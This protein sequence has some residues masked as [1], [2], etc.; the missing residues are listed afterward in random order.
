MKLYGMLLAGVLIGASGMAPTLKAVEETNTLEIIQRLQKRIDELEQK[1]KT[2]EQAQTPAAP[3]NETK[4]NTRLEELGQKVKALERERELDREAADAKAKEVPK[5]TLGERGFSLASADGAFAVQLGGVLQVDSRSFFNDGGTVGNDG[6]LLRRARPT[7]QGTV[8]RDFD[9]LFVPDF[10]TSANGGNGGTAPTPQIFDAY[11]NY[12]YS[13]AVQFQAGKFKAPIG[14]EQLQADRDILFNERALP[15]DLVPVRDI[16]FELH[17][18]LF[19]GTASYAAGVFNGVG[20]ARN[21][22]LSDFDDDKAFEGRIF[23][24]PFK[25]LS[26]SELQGFGFGLGG[27]YEGMQAANTAG[28]PN[29]NGFATV[30]L[31]QFFVYTNGVVAAGDHWRLSPQGYY[32]YGPFGLLGEYVISD[33]Y[34]SRPGAG[35]MR[36]D[37]KAWEI[38]GSWV[39]TGEDA[40]FAGGVLPRHPFEPAQGHWGAFQLVGRYSQ[41]DIDPAAFPLF[42]DPAAS[43]RSAREWSAGVNWYLN[44]NVRVDVSFSRTKFIGGGVSSSPSAPASVTRHDENVLFTRVQLAF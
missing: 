11:L 10:G 13:P 7:L 16:G 34:I 5:L 37:N 19:D 2:L 28:L 14:L 23:F 40:A 32:Y 21:S 43:A 38:T 41:L 31:Q 3:T 27:S 8:F 39:L 17:G 15:T 22:S 4:A 12:R 6:F 24:R 30:G 1:V 25:T 26:V 20:D 9:F 18:E 35:R 44:R 36:L 33:Q 42:A 29:G